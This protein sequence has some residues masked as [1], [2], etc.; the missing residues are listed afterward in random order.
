MERILKD[1]E[2]RI[3]A[4]KNLED[5]MKRMIE[6]LRKF[7]NE[8]NSMEFSI[9][10]AKLDAW[11]QNIF[12]YIIEIAREDGL[13]LTESGTIVPRIYI[14]MDEVRKG[15]LDR[16]IEMMPKSEPIVQKFLNEMISLGLDFI[17]SKET[18]R[19]KYRQIER[20]FKKK[21]QKV[22]V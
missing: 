22:K 3:E 13:S 2:D 18:A 5:L 12:N 7:K 21:I 1:I 14:N 9:N 20:E 15:L 17:A 16:G 6:T 10:S 11:T 8:I 4:L 19:E